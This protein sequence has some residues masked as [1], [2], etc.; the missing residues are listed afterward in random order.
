MNI[1]KLK[2]NKFKLSLAD[3][4]DAVQDLYIYLDK[5]FK[6]YRGRKIGYG[7]IS[8]EITHRL[9]KIKNK[10]S[11]FNL[12]PNEIMCDRLK[13]EIDD[14]ELIDKILIEKLIDDMS[15]DIK[16]IGLEDDLPF[17][18]ECLETDINKACRVFNYSS[19]TGWRKYKSFIKELKIH[20]NV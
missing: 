18:L 11:K 16:E 13:C 1:A 9:I 6:K 17:V 7:L 4:Q 15:Q 2:A 5:Y 14:E 8:N 20:Y 10:L 19:T 12:E 3:A